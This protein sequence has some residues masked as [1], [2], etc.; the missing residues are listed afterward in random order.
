MK[1]KV[2][3]ENGNELDNS[4]LD[5]ELGYLTKKEEGVFVY[6][7]FDEKQLAEQKIPKLKQLL[8]ETD[9]KAIK[10]AEGELSAEEYEPV[11]QQRRAWREEINELEKCET[12]PKDKP[13]MII[14]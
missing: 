8:A 14:T 3:D 6:H 11:K 9:Y 7:Y 13:Q 10:F 5:Y 4:T 12:K 1:I 2:L